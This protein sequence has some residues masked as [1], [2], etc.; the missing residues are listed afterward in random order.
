MTIKK[1]INWSEKEFSHLPWRNNRTLYRTL[2]SEIMLQQTTVATVKNH[3]E[4]FLTVFPN[5]ESLANSND[6]E[7]TVAWKG[8]GYYRRARNLKKIAQ[9]IVH[10]HAGNF[11]MD[12]ESLQKIP[13]IG[14]YTASAIVAIGMNKRALAVDA[15]LE[16]VISR[17]FGLKVLKG[18]KLQKTINEL[19][20]NQKI[21][22]DHKTPPRALNEA[23]MDLGRTYCQ[24]RKVSCEL[25]FLK[26]ECVAYKSGKPLLYPKVPKT[27]IEKEDHEL[28][29]LRFYIFKDSKILVYKKSENEWL[30]GQYEVPTYILKTTDPKLK[31]YP[32]FKGREHSPTAKFKT[33]IT[34]YKINNLILEINEKELAKLKFDRPLEWREVSHSRSNFSTATIK[35]LK[36]LG[37]NRDQE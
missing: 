13:G 30:S 16:R 2:V 27:Q 37:K 36:I 29:L 7:L 9:A 5:L 21:F 14:P 34:K 23:L 18:V 25:C 32:I 31:Q 6:E 24:A 1:L 4:R 19:F 3:Y 15:N 10:E 22:S 26:E 33:G 35:G 12:L 17:L 8:L 28:H 11:P 20:L